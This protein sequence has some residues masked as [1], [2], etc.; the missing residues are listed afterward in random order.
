MLGGRPPFSPVNDDLRFELAGLYRRPLIVWIRDLPPGWALKSVHYDGRDITGLPTDFGTASPQSRLEVVVTSRVAV[1][2]VRVTDEQGQPVTAYHV[3]LIPVD[4][5][6][7][8]RVVSGDPTTPDRD[9][10]ERLAP[11]L[12]GEYLVAALPW[13]D[14]LV[15]ARDP[16]RLE[17]LASVARRITLTEGDQ[18]LALRLAALPRARQ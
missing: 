16:S 9:G 2:V 4:P 10:V 17:S 12:P 13:E 15:L 18:T 11:R 8:Q 14:S 3:I 7:W 6:Q 5:A 1:P